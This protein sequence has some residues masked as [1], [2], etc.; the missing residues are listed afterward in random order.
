MGLRQIRDE[1][2]GSCMLDE[3]DVI[4]KWRSLF[5]GHVITCDSLAKAEALLEDFSRESPLHIRFATELKEI[6]KLQQK[7]PR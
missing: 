3:R 1:V 6:Q 2:K 4:Y 5:D 7:K